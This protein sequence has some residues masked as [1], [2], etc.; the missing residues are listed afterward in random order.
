MPDMPMNGIHPKDEGQM[1]SAPCKTKNEIKSGNQRLRQRE[2][3]AL[4]QGN[5]S[6]HKKARKG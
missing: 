2:N 6:F 4:S 1:H 3:R 5:L